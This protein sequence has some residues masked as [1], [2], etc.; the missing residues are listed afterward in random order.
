MS[1]KPVIMQVIP[2]LGA[3]G[4]EQ[5]AVDV[6]AAQVKAGMKA[7]VVSNGGP[8]VPEILR[9]GAQHIQLPV[10]SKNPFVMA[11]NVLRLRALIRKHDVLIVSCAQSRSRLGVVLKP[12]K[13]TNAHFMTTCHAPYNVRD[14]KFKRFLQ[15]R[16]LPRRVGHCQFLG[17]VGDYL[18]KEYKL[19]QKKNSGHSSRYS[20]GKS[21]SLA[22]S[23]PNE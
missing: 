2:N 1:K 6:A 8:R 4:A 19:S 7:I 20:H 13:G 22:W 11:L 12:S 23:P 3:G 14:N 16:Y 15:F 17:F 21:S 5:T 10:H 18:Q 9:C